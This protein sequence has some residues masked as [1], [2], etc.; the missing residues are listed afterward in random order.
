MQLLKRFRHIINSLIWLLAGLYIVLVV[1]V[2]IPVIQSAIGDTV[3]ST[4]SHKLGTP[5]SVGRVDVGGFNRIIVDN[6]AMLDK[7]GKQMLW[8]SR[9]SAKISYL[10]L[11]RGRVTIT[12]AQIFTPKLNLYK[13]S[14]RDAANFQ[15]VIDSL[16]SKDT[17]AHAP[18]NIAINSLVIRHGTVAWNQLDMPASQTFN[19]R[20][21]NITGLSSHIIVNA[22]GGDSLNVIIKK[23]SLKEGSGI[24]ISSL[25]AKATGRKGNYSL[26]NLRL[27]MPNS[28]VVI[29]IATVTTD[30]TAQHKM[31]YKCRLD[32]SHIMLSEL[33]PFVPALKD[34]KRQAVVMA[35]VYGTDN[36]LHVST[37]KLS[38][39][40][41][42]DAISISL[43]SDISLVASAALRLGKGTPGWNADIRQMSVK[44]GGMAMLTGKIPEALERLSSIDFRGK[45]G[46]SGDKLAVSG[47]L[48]SGAGNAN[49]D[50]A[51][52]GSRVKG[53]VSTAAFDIGHTL[54]D[55]RFG[56]IAADISV[57]GDIAKKTY[58]A[59]GGITRF[60]YNQY[61]YRNIK[62]DGSYSNG[63]VAGLFDIGDPNLQ[64]S[65]SGKAGIGSKTKDVQIEAGI[66]HFAPSALNLFNGQLAEAT[67]S[68]SV[69]ANFKAS[70]INDATGDIVVSLFH[71]SAPW[72]DYSID[73]LMLR[74][75]TWH[76]SH[77]LYLNSDFGQA[78]VYGQ[79][80]LQSLP[81]SIVN[82]IVHEL[83]SISNL[84]P[85]RYKP[86]ESGDFSISA[87]IHDAGWAKAFLKAP[88]SITDTLR[89]T[90]SVS[91]RANKLHANL[92][93]PDITY[94]DYHLKDIRA[95]IGN[96]GGKLNIG[97]SLKNMRSE[98]LG[99]D[100]SLKASAFDDRLE[101]SFS[102]DN[103]ASAQR[104]RGTL[105]SGI[106][107]GRSSSGRSQATLR[108]QQSHF[109][110]GDTLFT[111][112]PASVTYSKERL[113]VS[114]L[115]VSSNSQSI[116][117][118]GL[119]TADRN[120]SLTATL[121]NVD[122][123]YILNLVNFHSVEFGGAVSGNACVSQIFGKPTAYANLRVDNFKLIGGRLG[124]LLAR[125]D[126]NG[127]ENQIDI[128]AVAND[129]VMGRGGGVLP[130]QTTVKGYVSPK[131]NYLDL[132][133][134][135]N[136]T[137]A[138][139]VGNLCSSFLQDVELSGNGN[140]RLWGDLKKLN[141][142]GDII[143][144]GSVLVSP[145]GTAYS[146]DHAPVHFVENEI[147]F[148]QDTIH[149]SRGHAGIISGAIH[150]QHLSRMTYDIGIAAYDLL[151]FNLDGT[152]GSSFYGK[153]Y[154]TGD[155]TIKGRPGEVDID[156]RMTPESG[157]EV[158]YDITSPESISSQDF[159]HWSSRDSLG[160]SGP[161][162]TIP[163]PGSQ[164][165]DIPTDIHLNLQIN[166]M[167]QA[168]LRLIM[169][170]A[171]G[172]YITLNGSGGLRATYFNKGGVNIFGTYT[173]DHGVYSL[174][175]Q[176]I[177]KR[178]FDF[179][180][181]GTIIF[182][183][184]PYS[185][186]LNLK[187][188][189][190]IA[191]VS[192]ADLQVGRS[193]SASNV[194]A[195][196]LMD[197][198]GTPAA[199]KVAFSLD[200]PTM[201]TDAKQMVYSLINGEEEMNQQVLYLLAVGRFYSRGTNNA[202][203]QG[204]QTSLAMQSILSG[205]LSQQINSVL[206][207]VVKTSNW[208][209]GANI[210]TGDEGFNNA[211]YE[212][213]LTGHLLNNRLLFNGQFGYRDKANATTSFIGDFDVRYLITPNG[214][215]SIHVY[216]QANDRYFTRS[217]LNTQGFGIILK[218]DFGGLNDL[219]G[220][221]KSKK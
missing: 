190:P 207:N 82:S 83:P 23:L 71:M 208:N 27:D 22:A 16:S 3:A 60:D 96:D 170:K 138:E 86:V 30:S 97:A 72:T 98:R 10:D 212:G 214:N 12:S 89:F 43:P 193:F 188:Q 66:G 62:I 35:S 48:I 78:I 101:A 162:A 199:P 32:E 150:H 74:A 144:H 115:A 119:A 75:G 152:D 95:D 146:L 147:Q 142:T 4:I 50:V 5:V 113:E 121:R 194:R 112:H 61:S 69:K 102:I 196:C 165:I 47:Q 204:N 177:I 116:M 14:A 54:A 41:K 216:N 206:S 6:F 143:A 88:L 195:N 140:L 94:G 107:F 73:S 209:F 111:I 92:R 175:I 21:V 68:A 173:I 65:I 139:F 125:V 218:K 79:F 18:V 36:M 51:K 33:S 34:A 120:D 179:T 84:A 215:F 198:T 210:S 171:S 53:S 197:I 156:L 180:Q 128:D 174:T 130:R 178:T 164:D 211:Q 166:A 200:F 24:N 106:A 191:S 189:Y 167:P 91:D 161:A 1:M 46:G 90:A 42:H 56:L 63:L 28:S 181:G 44:A 11:M 153:V 133:M 26:S 213:T 25:T 104:L 158:V 184:D 80:H 77:F 220:I 137:R 155:A 118:D 40:H 15:F 87:S 99:T 124:T 17:T 100:L 157:S 132:N 55:G 127:E 221:K 19:T 13:A 187:A 141:L 134:G 76:K 57:E 93:A 126:W 185:A 122:V 186:L 154:A 219:L 217:S 145:L 160:N 172:D 49:V 169:D 123:D 8:V 163:T 64:A 205:Q 117:L 159:I 149:D 108:I 202:N 85:L 182:G 58:K 31:A 52:H 135:L 183:G 129:T 37:F 2:H 131:R 203:S 29:P 109:N 105:N 39:P 103:H 192:L 148:R 136:E 114:R 168:M 81:Q 67:Y 110:V 176:N 45:A 7:K 38:V 151:A 59:I 201:S 20:H 70:N 9:L